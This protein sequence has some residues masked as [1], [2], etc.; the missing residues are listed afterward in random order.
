MGSGLLSAPPR[1]RRPARQ[2]LVGKLC[3]LYGLCGRFQPTLRGRPRANAPMCIAHLYSAITCRI[4]DFWRPARSKLGR[5]PFTGRYSSSS[6]KVLKTMRNRTWRNSLVIAALCAA[7]VCTGC[8]SGGWG[9]PKSSWVSWGKQKPEASSIA[10]TRAEPEPPS[11]SY[12]PYQANESSQPTSV[13][14]A[15]STSS[16]STTPS[17]TG[18]VSETGAASGYASQQP[19]GSPGY[20]TG[21]Y[22]TGS[23]AAA[24]TAA[25]N[26]FYSPSYPNEQGPAASTADARS[27]SYPS[28]TSAG[29]AYGG[30]TPSPNTGS[31]PSSYA[32]PAS[33]GATPGQ[34][35][36][37]GYGTP[38]A[39]PSTSYSAA[40]PQT[41]SYQTTPSSGGYS[42]AS[43]PS[44]H[45]SDEWLFNASDVQPA[46][47]FKSNGQ[48]VLT[49]CQHGCVATFEFH[50]FER[51]C[52][53]D[54]RS[55]E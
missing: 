22:S 48:L 43:T 39:A 29:S 17:S 27:G 19:A 12:P 23:G 9:M 7:F 34:E 5:T 51:R 42:A 26:N 4:H 2:I 28:Q 36:P 44:A 1:V 45:R 10:G 8:K 52:R 13:A 25:Q 46:N 40:A 33:Y 38:A 16:S 47:R 35:M 49:A 53:L 15:A 41:P 3:G 50:A 55:A 6:R 11:I 32:S 18:Y 54:I 31:Y 30:V 14:S 21:P 37:A 24:R 20:A